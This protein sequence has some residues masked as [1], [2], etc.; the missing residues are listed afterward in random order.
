MFIY[1]IKINSKGLVKIL[2]IIIAIIITMYFLFSAY[3][4]YTNSFKVNDEI[5]EEVK[6]KKEKKGRTIMKKDRYSST[7]TA[8]ILG[9]IGNIFLLIIKD[10]FV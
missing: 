1:N 8:S 7:K 9:I 2:F 3:K 6:N 5:V 10:L 4:I